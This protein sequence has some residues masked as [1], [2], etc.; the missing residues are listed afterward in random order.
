MC[1]REEPYTIYNPV[2]RKVAIN[3]RYQYR[4]FYIGR[5]IPLQKST[6]P[7]KKK[8]QGQFQVF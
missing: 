2:L 8:I 7:G 4:Q 3:F 6:S 5:K 1:L